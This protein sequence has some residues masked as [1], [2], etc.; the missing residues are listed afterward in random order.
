VKRL[1]VS[2]ESKLVSHA[3]AEAHVQPSPHLVFGVTKNR[4]TI[5][6]LQLFGFE[7]LGGFS[8]VFG[9][10]AATLLANSTMM[11]KAATVAF[12]FLGI[13]AH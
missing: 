5:F 4:V 3:S 6:W 10:S 13:V 1:I 9:L 8:T 11:N 12:M 2:P 7:D